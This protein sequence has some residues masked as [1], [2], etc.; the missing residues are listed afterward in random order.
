MGQKINSFYEE[1][2]FVVPE[3]C[4]YIIE[5]FKV[6]KKDTKEKF[7]L[8][9]IPKDVNLLMIKFLEEELLK[10]GF[11]KLLYNK[12]Y[13]LE[14]KQKES[15]KKKLVLMLPGL[16]KQY[17]GI[18]VLTT[19]VAAYLDLKKGSF[20]PFIDECIKNN[21][22][23]LILDYN[24]F[25]RMDVRKKIKIENQFIRKYYQQFSKNYE[26]IAIIAHSFGGFH[27][28]N[29]LSWL[30]NSDFEK[31]KAIA[32]ADSVHLS[33][34]IKGL[35]KMLDKEKQK[36]FDEKCINWV[37]SKKKLDEDCGTD[38]YNNIKNLSAGTDNHPHTNY[39]AFPSITK[40]VFQKI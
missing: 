23:V 10:R 30:K 14:T 8:N 27:T 31:I 4:E 21:V 33:Y 15:S 25:Q 6:V 19:G 2:E 32:F 37:T 7:C 3:N 13:H 16:R 22:D 34:Q 36:G 12:A 35:G 9:S 28:M 40:H 11:K 1:D 18:S 29:L 26:N 17:W 24:I 20:I 38:E 39:S 5:D